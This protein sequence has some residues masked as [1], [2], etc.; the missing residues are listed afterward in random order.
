MNTKEERAADTILETETP[1]GIAY[2]IYPAGIPVR[3]AAWLIDVI[4][5]GIFFIAVLII[6]GVFGRILGIWFIMLITFLFT[7][8]YHTAFEIF[9][10]GQSPGKKIMGLRVVMADGSSVGYG[11]SFLRNLM[12]F[13]DTFFFLYLAAFICMI[14]S[15]EF[16][17]IGD[18]IG[19]TLVVY[20]SPSSGRFT[21]PYFRQSSMPWLA[22]FPAI[23]AP[24]KLNYEE[25][26]LI[27]SFARRFPLLGR[28]RADEIAKSWHGSISIQ[29]ETEPS[30]YLMGIAR[31]IGGL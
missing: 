25:K 24:V 11:A 14:I 28:A 22:D 19:G 8:F 2:S 1:E 17:R 5:Q 26:Q 13:A 9:C 12:R 3:A 23:P 4:F 27:L 18:W 29:E 16:R 20:V 6:A 15:P 10:R 7:W 21:S 30:A 31:S